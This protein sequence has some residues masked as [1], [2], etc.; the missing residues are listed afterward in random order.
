MAEHT[1]LPW[2]AI[3]GDTL[4]LDRQWGVSRYLSKEDCEEIDGDDATWPSRTEVIAEIM[5]GPPGLAEAD[6]KFI[7]KA[8]N[9]H[10]E[11]LAAC[12]AVL[13]NETCAGAFRAAMNMDEKFADDCP[14]Y[15]LDCERDRDLFN[16]L[17]AAIAKAE[18]E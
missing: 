3:E 17:T 15:R 12:K 7:A 8:C 9:S 11:L 18:G 4:S 10:D 16:Q 13:A 2:V 1:E 5:P 6:A 14:D